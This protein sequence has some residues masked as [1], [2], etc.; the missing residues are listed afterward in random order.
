MIAPWIRSQVAAI[1][2]SLPITVTTL[3]DQ[4]SSLADGPRF[5]TLLVC[6]F[7]GT[8]FCLAL[9][10][11]Y[12]V[13]SLLVTQRTQEFG[14]RLAL[15]DSRANILLLVL[16]QNLRMVA[17]GIAVGFICSLAMAKFLASLL[18]HVRP[19]DPFSFLGVS[20][21][22]AMSAVGA[23]LVPATNATQVDPVVSLRYE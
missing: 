8:G 16:D 5:Q 19:Y 7:A 3:D 6:A 22:L 14:L 13:V 10:G 9:I 11:V 2:P 4:V 21:V 18:F 17:I 23:A 20:V 12:G 1:D 15:G